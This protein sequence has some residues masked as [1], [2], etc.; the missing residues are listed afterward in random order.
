MSISYDEIG[1][2]HVT[3]PAGTCV[4]GKIC[5]VGTDGKAAAAAS[6]DKFC[7][8]AKVVKNGLASVQLHGFATVSYSGNAPAMGITAL[9]ADGTGGV[10]S[11][12]I[13]R[14]YL[15]VAVDTVA[16]TATIEL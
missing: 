7:G 8:V 10:K 4:E 13:G 5:K 16:K 14:S 1:A 3:V 9:S 2:L 15:I 11:D 6:G 12:S